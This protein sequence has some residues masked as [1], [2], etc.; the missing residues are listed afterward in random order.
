M[1]EWYRRM[2]SNI[3]SGLGHYIEMVTAVINNTGM[4]ASKDAIQYT[5]TKATK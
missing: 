1:I 5:T 2:I 4:F 3:F